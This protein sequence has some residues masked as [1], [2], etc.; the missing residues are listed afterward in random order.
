MI[1]KWI[2]RIVR[3]ELDAAEE[4]RQKVGTTSSLYIDLMKQ[5]DEFAKDN[6]WLMEIVKKDRGGNPKDAIKAYRKELFD[7]MKKNRPVDERVCGQDSIG[8]KDGEMRT[9]KQVQ[10]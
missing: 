5:K 10:A 4:R 3:T 1:G 7:S 2:S 6:Y 8:A 9:K